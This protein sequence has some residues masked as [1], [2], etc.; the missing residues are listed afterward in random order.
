MKRNDTPLLLL[1]LLVVLAGC[2][3]GSGGGTGAEE[4]GTTTA[5]DEGTSPAAG[6]SGSTANWCTEGQRAQFSNPETGEQASW[7]VQ[8][9]VEE[10]GRQ[11]CKAVWET[12][13]GETRRIEMFY[14]EDE[15]YRKMITYDA[16]GEQIDEFVVSGG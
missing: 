12:N 10:D 2:A 1:V 13:Q 11:V 8:G 16:E 7:E 5:M 3:G 14:T 15:S 6:D 9:L 4:G